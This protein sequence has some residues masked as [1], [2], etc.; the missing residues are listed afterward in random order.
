MIDDQP[1]R[2]YW[3]VLIL[4]IVRNGKRLPKLSVKAEALGLLTEAILR[5]F[6]V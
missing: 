1:C 5:L 2:L 6:V 4:L 3:S